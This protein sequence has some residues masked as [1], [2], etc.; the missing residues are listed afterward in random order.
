MGRGDRKSRCGKI[1][2]GTY[3]NSR[4][5]KATRVANQKTAAAA[6]AEK[7]ADANKS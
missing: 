7:S 4:L 2:R 1:W 3:G 6:A 5:R